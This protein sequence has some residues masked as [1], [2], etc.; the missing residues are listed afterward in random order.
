M[1]INRFFQRVFAAT[2]LAITINGHAFAEETKYGAGLTGEE[3]TKVSAL[4][5]NPDNYVGKTVRIEGLI[6]DVCPMRGCWI[7]LAS[8]REFEKMR[9]KVKDG[10]IVFP[11]ESKGKNAVV[12]GVFT[13]IDLS[14]ED[15][16]RY[17]RHMAE[18]KNL[19]F[20]E[21][22]VTGPMKIY[23]IKGAGGV[24]K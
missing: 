23:Q 9:F 20:D 15:A 11:V 6:V 4:M 16:I 10:E 8:D 22:S 1:R 18:E 21:A 13:V 17:Q 5:D 12:E 19:P 7:D 3:L 14:H 2:L 24:V